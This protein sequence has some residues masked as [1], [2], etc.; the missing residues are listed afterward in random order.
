MDLRFGYRRTG[1]VALLERYCLEK[2]A[3]FLAVDILEH[4]G[5]KIASSAIRGHVESGQCELAAK[6]LGYPYFIWGEVVHGLERG[7]ELSFPTANLNIPPQ[8][9]IPAD[10][11]YAVAAL[12]KGAWKGGALSIGK[13]P[14]FGDVPEIRVEVFIVDYEGDLY[15]EKLPVLFLS[16]LRPQIQFK[17]VDQLVMQID[18]DVQRV[19]SVFRHSFEQHPDWYAGFLIAYV[20][21]MTQL[22]YEIPKG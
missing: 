3:N 9:L 16:R 5:S 8:K 7:R 1:D 4:L 10:G 20:E 19:K 22:G 15:E 13:N 6:E 14:T 12:V 11:V 21:I 17:N 18:A 2:G